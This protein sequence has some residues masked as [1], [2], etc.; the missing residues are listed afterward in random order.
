M[1][2]SAINW[3]ISASVVWREKSTTWAPLAP[4][5]LVLLLNAIVEVKG[6]LIMSKFEAL[7]V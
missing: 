4:L 1:P 7:F 3:M 5:V 6:V 2:S